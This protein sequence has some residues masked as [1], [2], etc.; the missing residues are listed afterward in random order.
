MVGGL[1][2]LAIITVFQLLCSAALEG[3]TQTPVEKIVVFGNQAKM[4]KHYLEDDVPKGIL[5]DILKHVEAQSDLRF[6]IRLYPWM[7]SY[8][9][10]VEGKGGI[11]GLSKNRE[12]LK[13][14]DYSDVMFYDDLILVV[15]KGNEFEYAKISDLKGKVIGVNR[16]GSYGDAFE[17]GKKNLFTIDEDADQ[18]VRLKKLLHKRFDA[19]LIGPGKLG[20]E[21]AFQQDEELRNNRDKFVVLP[22]PFKRDPNYMGF[23]KSQNKQGVSK[24]IQ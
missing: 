23:A 10:A 12:R 20:L 18:I 9:Y 14:F 13:V 21:Y 8:S 19:A 22:V 16:G 3:Q 5:I 4:P 1:R 17:N 7:R 2:I 11:I 15:L 6:D 24:R